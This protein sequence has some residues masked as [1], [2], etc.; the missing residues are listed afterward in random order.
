MILL[1]IEDIT[2]TRRAERRLAAEHA[3]ARVLAR[4]ASFDEAAPALLDAFCAALGVEMA[5][6]WAPADDG[7]H[8]ALAAFH[9]GAS[10]EGVDAWREA[11]S[12]VTFAPG[13]GLPGRVWQSREPAWIEDVRQ[14]PGFSRVA[15]AAHLDLRAG[16][17]FP[18]LVG[19]TCT[20][21]MS[22]F[23]REAL[24]LDGPLLDMMAAIGQE[25]GQFVQRTRAEKLLRLRIRQQA[26]VA[27]LGQSA[28]SGGALPVL[29]E[30]AVRLVAETL[31]VEL[32]KILA[33]LPGRQ[34]HLLTA[35]VGWEPGQVG[36]TMVGVGPE[37]QAG[38]TLS[39]A[40]PVIVRDLRTETRFSAPPL[41]REHG[42]VSGVSV[43]I[44]G[45][46][47]R[48]PY[49]LL[50]AHTRRGREFTADDAHFLQSVANVLAGAVQRRRA[51]AALG[52]SE[53]QLRRVLDNLFAF[54]GVL[55][56]EGV[57]I[58]TNRAPL[59]AA[60]ITFADV[61]GRRFEDCHWWSY[62][63]DVQ[64]Q[65]RDAIMRAARGELV[66]YDVDVRV[67]G[68][69]LITI[70]F[71][72]APLRDEAGRITHLIPSAV[73]ITERRRLTELRFQAFLDATPDAMVVVSR[74]GAIR[75]LN[76]QAEQLFGYAHDEFVG[77]PVEIL[78]PA[79]Y[80]ARH[81]QHKERYL[82]APA[83]KSM[84]TGL[85]IWG[86]TNDG[87]EIPLEVSLSPATMPDGTNSVIAAARDVTEQHRAQEILEAAK[88]EAERENA[89][90]SR[91]L[92]ATSHDLRQPL[93]TLGLLQGVLSRT[94]RDDSTRGVIQNL[95]DT[96]ASMASTIDA[97]L[98]INQL[99]SGAVRPEVL[100]F[101]VSSILS[102]VGSEYAHLAD[103]KGLE[104]RVVP[105]SAVIRSDPRLLGR[106][107]D[108]LTSN[109]IKYTEAGK[110]LVGCHR[111][112]GK[113]RIEVWDT[114][115]GIPDDQ[116]EA[117]FEEYHQL[118]NPARERSRGLGLGLTVV[119]RMAELL[120]H[121]IDMRST[122]GRGSMF[123]V[124]VPLGQ[125][126]PE[127]APAEVP[128]AAVTEGRGARVLLVEDDAPVR[129]SLEL[130]LGLEGYEVTAA[131]TAHEALAR[132]AEGSVQPRIL[133]ADH[134]LPGGM[135]GVDLVGRLRTRVGQEM[136]AIVLTGDASVETMR[137]ITASGAIY[138][139][140]PVDAEK[141]LRLIEQ[142]LGERRETHGTKRAVEAMT[143]VAPAEQPGRP[144]VSVVD[145]DPSIR[146]AI[147]MLL[148][149]SR[150]DAETF[151][152]CEAFLA[153]ARPECCCIR[154]LRK[155]DLPTPQQVTPLPSLPKA[156]RRTSSSTSSA[157]AGRKWYCTAQRKARVRLTG[158]PW[159]TLPSN[160]SSSPACSG[161]ATRWARSA[162]ATTILRSRRSPT[163]TTPR[164]RPASSCVRARSW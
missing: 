94:V 77:R 83:A 113:L 4:A 11:A 163:S 155:I 19:E 151:G 122:L 148:E 75:A 118:D 58:W 55:T 70:D 100:N 68:G 117:I 5:E 132:V 105:C 90:K 104:L 91:F 54:V 162:P 64:A 143:A 85:E 74:E 78:M 34:G 87:R 18:I 86:L 101:P 133:I 71:M 26:A 6:V 135:S 27:D 12:R 103:T 49:G 136:A 95:G 127:A 67:A 159:G 30:R 109:A 92:A 124:E 97:L 112:G 73:D 130:F 149:A 7:R 88:A 13:V 46:E 99:E 10:L 121:R 51:E 15:A 60:A 131:T 144:L 63:S 43:V 79:R 25:I 123:A 21:V 72:L 107:V 39:V 120:G 150:Y 61:R 129:E 82:S 106:L 161:S 2:E 8:L 76:R 33:L 28:L 66:R 160:S 108:N 16:F 93:Q 24:A 102:R 65:L 52:E 153:R 69:R 158:V 141:L 37:S 89:F 40:E 62:S 138:L 128:R 142:L 59:E 9:S 154:R 152:T 53:R 20:G 111:R 57:V 35:G 125:S 140:K 146:D 56:T 156:A 115:V 147:R 1:S 41:L 17:A 81:V 14:D 48:A 3:V 23:T 145:D 96:I 42:A 157:P 47:G 126:R 110:V 84:G 44:A 80:R 134:N 164:W 29:M 32:C 116:L 38:Y 139:R 119:Q 31:D 50:G 114:G 36:R 22:F 98:D 45:E 137:E